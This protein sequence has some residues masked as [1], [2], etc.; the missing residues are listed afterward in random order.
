VNFDRWEMASGSVIILF[1]GDVVQAETADGTEV[2][3]FSYNTAMLR[4]ASHRMEQTVYSLLR[5]DR[6]RDGQSTVAAIVGHIFSIL[7]LYFSMPGFASQDEVALLQLKSLFTGYYDYVQHHPK[8]RPRD[9]CS[10]RVTELFNTFMEL[11]NQHCQTSRDVAYYAQ[12]MNV[13]TKY[14]SQIVNRK[15]HRTPKTIIDHYVV[16]QLKLSLRTSKKS[17]KEIGWE[18]HFTDDSFFCRYF[19]ARTGLS[20]QQYRK[21]CSE[22]S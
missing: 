2:E 19:K 10:Q 13:S 1:P 17:I 11:V 21:Q 15:T 3:V 16:M 5:M 22:G 7:R 20:P 18:Y 12:E 6:C 4:E 14:L 8:V 9:D